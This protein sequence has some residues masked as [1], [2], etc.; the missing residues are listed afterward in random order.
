LHHR[1]LGGRGK[2]QGIKLLVQK[3]HRGRRLRQVAELQRALIHVVEL[4]ELAH[5]PGHT[6]AGGADIHAQGFEV[7]QRFQRLG[8]AVKQ[9]QRLDKQAAQ[10]AQLRLSLRLQVAIA[11]L[12]KSQAHLALGQPLQVL[13]RTFGFD[14]LDG[15]AV[16]CQRRG[17]AFAKLVVS[18][19]RRAGGQRDLARRHRVEPQVSERQQGR[20]QKH[21]RPGRG[22]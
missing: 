13:R 19:L 9:P 6:T 11:T 17:V 3:R 14:Q 18:A 8:A 15:N 5:Q 22:Q 1:R 10:R 12:D 16:A 4:K 21:K 7:A 20:C 2:Q